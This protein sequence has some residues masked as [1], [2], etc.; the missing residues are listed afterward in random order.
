MLR[1][2]TRYVP[3][4]L[5]M[6]GAC[7][8]PTPREARPAPAA[9]TADEHEA[10]AAR[11]RVAES[12]RAVVEAQERVREAQ[13]TYDAL[14]DRSLMLRVAV[15]AH[16]RRREAARAAAR[17][18]KPYQ[19]LVTKLRDA[20]SALE[21]HDGTSGDFRVTMARLA[22]LMQASE[23]RRPDAEENAR[24]DRCL[25][26]ARDEARALRPRNDDDD[27]D[28]D[29]DAAAAAAAAMVDGFVRVRWFWQDF[30][31]SLAAEGADEQEHVQAR[32]EQAE[33]SQLYRR[34]SDEL[35]DAK[36]TLREHEAA[37]SEA[38]AASRRLRGISR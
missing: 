5:L 34:A 33:V 35:E 4:L 28:D 9:H 6:T 24:W 23:V 8:P 11:R 20:A 29:D 7:A 22:D 27:D 16:D 26:Q 37:L 17:D 36:R 38:R 14:R 15:A 31:E 19:A 10:V 13:L 32:R 12:E 25:L 21:Q 3:F 18:S 1:D 2:V 30:D